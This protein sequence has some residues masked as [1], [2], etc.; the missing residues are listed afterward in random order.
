MRELE[1]LPNWYPNLRRRKRVVL[2]QG[3]MTL[4]IV[5]G[6]TLWIVLARQNL[7]SA[8]ATLSV[9]DRE[10][11]QTRAEQSQLEELLALE[12]ELTQKEQIIAQL[13]FPVEMS[14][15]LRTLDLVMPPEM[16]VREITCNT[17]EV[18]LT[19]ATGATAARARPQTPRPVEKR[20]E[21]RLVGWAP[22]DVDLANFLA[23]L[24]TDYPFFESI[25]L[26]RADGKSEGGHLLREFEVTFTINLESPTGP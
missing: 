23:G 24:Q 26:V 6:L 8:Q 1:F 22:S 12:R 5:A 2:L 10:M 13:G 25:Q 11:V 21:F 9:L 16:S 14:R 20:L 18:V 17:R 7:Q 4:A 15:V 3:W 19:A